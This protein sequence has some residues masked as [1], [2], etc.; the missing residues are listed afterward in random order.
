MKR[1]VR[2]TLVGEL[3][4]A[5]LLVALVLAI[6]CPPSLRAVNKVKLHGYITGRADDRTLLILDDKLEMTAATRVL[7]QDATGEHP[8]KQEELQPGM[9]IEAEGQWLDRHKFFPEK[10]TIDLREN[11]KKIH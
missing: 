5:E 9:L 8:M 2:Q 4:A 10:I 6:C 1:T 7:G 11:D 3:R